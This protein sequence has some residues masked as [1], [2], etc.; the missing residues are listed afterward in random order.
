MAGRS[1]KTP[2]FLQNKRADCSTPLKFYVFVTAL[3]ISDTIIPIC[4]F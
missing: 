4:L 1:H 3:S 2:P